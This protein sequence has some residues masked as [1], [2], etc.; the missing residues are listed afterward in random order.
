M[1]DALYN[2]SSRRVLNTVKTWRKYARENDVPLTIE[3]LA[4]CLKAA[5]Q[6]IIDFVNL[7]DSDIKALDAE[8]RAVHKILCEA[9]IGA[10]ADNVEFA[11]KKGSSVG[12]FL[13]EKN[14][15][16]NDRK[17]DEKKTVVIVGEEK[18]E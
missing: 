14:Y 5:H 11:L 10:T 8:Q 15:G 12:K 2:L 17:T 6:D 9:Y 4:V 18:I 1:G 7:D 16:Y 13:L 3:R